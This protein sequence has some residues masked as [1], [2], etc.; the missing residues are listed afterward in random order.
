[1]TPLDRRIAQD[2]GRLKLRVERLEAAAA[3]LR[4]VRSALGETTRSTHTRCPVCAEALA[5][6]DA[7]LDALDNLAPGPDG[8]MEPQEWSLRRHPGAGVS[9]DA[10]ELT[11][12]TA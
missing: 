1:M 8:G 12:R 6:A 11:A 4:L 2:A 5:R 3:A 10:C 9:L 7:A